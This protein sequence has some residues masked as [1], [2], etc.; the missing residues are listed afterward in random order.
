L[1]IFSYLDIRGPSIELLRFQGYDLN[2]FSDPFTSL[3]KR[4]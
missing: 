3:E 1:L 4:K 2:P